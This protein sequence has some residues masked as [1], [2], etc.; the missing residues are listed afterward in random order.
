VTNVLSLPVIRPATRA[1]IDQLISE[2]LPYRIR[3][4]AVEDH[5]GKLLGVGGFAYQPQDTI[6][7]FVLKAPGAERYKVALHRAGL[8]AM[9]EAKAAGF[10]R[11]V[12]L[13]EKTNPAA[14]R[15]LARLGFKQVMVE[16]EK[17]WVW[18][19]SN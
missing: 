7:A 5:E 10:R 15:W 18:E 4:F 3:A 14:E 16:G 2:P 17:A 13:A 1:D 11:V 6:A 12:A 9:A 19:A 8:M